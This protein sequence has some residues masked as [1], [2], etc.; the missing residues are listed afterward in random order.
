MKNIKKSLW[1]GQ[2]PQKSENQLFFGFGVPALGG[3]SQENPP[4][5]GALVCHDELLACASYAAMCSFLLRSE[6]MTLKR[7]HLLL[8]RYGMDVLAEIAND[9]SALDFLEL[10]SDAH[11]FLLSFLFFCN[12]FLFI[13]QKISVLLKISPSLRYGVISIWIGRRSDG[14]LQSACD[15]PSYPLPLC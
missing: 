5:Y 8:E 10:S 15:P 9:Y 6:N 7:A 12:D 2:S 13:Y 3:F 11:S 1:K 4:A 14:H